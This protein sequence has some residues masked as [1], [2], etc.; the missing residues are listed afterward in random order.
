MKKPFTKTI[1]AVVSS[2]ALCVAMTGCSSLMPSSSAPQNQAVTYVAQ[3]NQVA[4]ALGVDLTTFSA[5]LASGDM[6]QIRA[7]VD[8]VTKD[9][10]T[11]KAIEATGAT[12]EVKEKYDAGCEAL[13]DALNQYLAL[14]ES[15]APVSDEAMQAAQQRYIEGVNLLTEAD[16]AAAELS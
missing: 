2:A 11:L 3:V 6:D 4:N 15:Q 12:A 7:A 16:K 13:L 5:A 14:F 1:V 8:T 10:E 9:L